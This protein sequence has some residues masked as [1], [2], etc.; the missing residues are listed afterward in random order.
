[1]GKISYKDK[2]KNKNLF[3]FFHEVS[4]TEDSY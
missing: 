2:I 4:T 1:M 3:D